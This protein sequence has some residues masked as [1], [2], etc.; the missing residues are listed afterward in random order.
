MEIAELR[1]KNDVNIRYATKSSEVLAAELKRSQDAVALVKTAVSKTELDRQRLAVEKA[2]LEIEQAQQDMSEQEL[3]HQLKVNEDARAT[4]A[5]ERRLVRAPISGK[6]MEVSKSRG[7]WVDP[8]NPVFRV[9]RIDQLRVKG[10]VNIN[11]IIGV[12][13][14]RPATLFI[15]VPGRP[16]LEFPGKLAF[17]SLEVN[18]VNGEQVEVWAEV[19][20]K[21]LLLR[22]GM[23]G[24]L[25]IQNP[26][27]TAK[28]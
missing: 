12:T 21:N 19:E 28:K 27:E 18:E 26:T 13:E 17:I 25:V 2:E 6:V 4:P 8:G 23:H 1:S 24:T 20:N 10:Y 15:D 7:E 16:R 9:V 22:P 5:V 3:N 14:G 11:Q